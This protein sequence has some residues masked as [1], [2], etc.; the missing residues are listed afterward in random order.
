M[1]ITSGVGPHFAWLTVNGGTFPI[2]NGSV[3]QQAQRKSSTFSGALPLSYPGAEETLAALGDNTAFITVSTRGVQQRLVTGEID[4]TDFDYVERTIRFT[5]RD[6]S[7]KLHDNKTS[8]KWQNKKGSEIVSDLAGRVGLETNIAQSL[9]LAGKKL[10]QDYVRLS[11][12]ISFA[13]VIHKLA[14]FDGARWWVDAQGM[15]H[16]QPLNSPSGVYTLNYQPPL[17]GPMSAD[18]MGLRIRRNVQ[19]GKSVAVTVKSW[20]PKQKKVFSETSNVEGRGGPIN[21]NYHIPNLL[22]DH[23]K[24][25]A[26]SQATEKSRHELTLS[27]DIV[28]D[29][30]INIGMGLQLNG[31]GFWDQL[32]E[33]DTIHHVFG[34]RGHRTHITARAG[35][36]GRTAS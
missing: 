17:V 3:E 36:G 2:E 1:A 8:E 20:H 27:A 23:V 6:K 32:Y 4:T 19:A 14:E 31:T 5:G 24:R 21:Y 15:F 28:G 30:T 13:Y 22:K 16:Y 11:D 10:E 34:M 7:S 29:P 35:L 25:H 33:M 26:Q 9:L 18:F 12:N